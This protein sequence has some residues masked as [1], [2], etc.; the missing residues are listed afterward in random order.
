MECDQTRQA[1]IDSTSNMH[2]K[3]DGMGDGPCKGGDIRIP[4]VFDLSEAYC[5]LYTGARCSKLL[6]TL[7]LMNICTTHGCSN[8]FLD[9]L[10]SLLHKFIIPVDNYLP[11]TMYHAKSLIRKLGMECNIIHACKMGC[12]LYKGVYVDLQECPKCGS[13]RYK[14]VGRTQIPIKMLCHFPII[15]HL[16]RFYRSLAISKLLAAWR[17]ENKST[18]GLVRHVVDSKACMHIDNKWPNFA[19]D[20][21]NIRFGL[22][23]DG[24]NPFSNKTCIWSTWPVILLVYNLP[25]WMATKRFFMLLTLL[26]PGKEQVKLENNDV[27]LQPLIDELQELW[28]PGVPAWDLSKQP[29]DQLFNLRAMVIWTI[30]DYPR[31]GL[32][33]GCAYQ[34]Y[35]ACLLCGPDITSRYSKPLL[36]CVYYESQRWLPEDHPYRHP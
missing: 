1:G 28:Q 17:H 21:I 2:G 10:L 8:K 12:I 25:P 13:P 6:A 14:Q 15:P 3:Q 16:I 29:N 19:T 35:K 34:G 30:H 5:P 11:P 26:I 33:T 18:N 36:K 9:Q 27:Y 4:S 31:Y 7:V 22:A 24:F 32:L 23:I 20:P